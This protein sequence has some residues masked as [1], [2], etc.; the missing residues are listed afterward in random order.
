MPSG[1]GRT[2]LFVRRVVPA[3]VPEALRQAGA[4]VC[5]MNG[6]GSGV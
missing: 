2:R 4:E 1:L 3:C 6:G 5:S